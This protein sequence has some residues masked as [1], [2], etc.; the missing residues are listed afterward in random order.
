MKKN[1]LTRLS[2]KRKA[3]TFGTIVFTSVALGTT[4]FAAWVMSMNT[5]DSVQGNVSVGLVEGGSLS[6]SNV[7]ISSE[8]QGFYFEP[9][10][11]DVTGRV[12]Y[13]SGLGESLEITVSGKISPL[14]ELGDLYYKIEI[15]QGVKDA[16]DAGYIV[17]PDGSTT[18]AKATSGEA[19]VE[20]EAIAYSG[21]TGTYEFSFD[22]AFAWGDVFGGENPGL[23]YDDA[24]KDISYA[25]VKRTLEDFRAILYGYA[26]DLEAIE[27]NL[28]YDET[29]KA[30][31]R[32]K[33][34]LAHA[35]DVMPTFTVFVYAESK[36]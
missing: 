15:P 2:F 7:A 17:L 22:V 1:R 8:S 16:A 10:V 23:Y 4:G 14:E 6:F 33:V 9:K 36:L 25:E 29:K 5:E 31:E 28:E 13:K 34:I 11:E 21:T 27:N 35:E 18:N 12:K 20:G 3:V 24:G 30:E 26:E 32:D 19:Y